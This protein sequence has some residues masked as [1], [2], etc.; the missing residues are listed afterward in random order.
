MIIK[1]VNERKIEITVGLIVL[2]LAFILNIWYA[3]NGYGIRTNSLHPDIR[4]QMN[5]AEIELTE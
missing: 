4:A 1:Q 2:V 3:A 5:R